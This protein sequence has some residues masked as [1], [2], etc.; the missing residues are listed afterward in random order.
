MR[1]FNDATAVDAETLA[2]CLY[3]TPPPPTAVE[4]NRRNYITRTCFYF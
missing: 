4:I 2:S 3:S 1:L